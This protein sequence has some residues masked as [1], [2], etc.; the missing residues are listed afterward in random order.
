MLHFKFTYTR[1]T[2]HGRILEHVAETI[3][4]HTVKSVK[5]ALV[6]RFGLQNW[7]PWRKIDTGFVKTRNAHNERGK[8]ILEVITSPNRKEI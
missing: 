3:S 2:T 1:C 6:K 5:H 7:S 8:I 4:G